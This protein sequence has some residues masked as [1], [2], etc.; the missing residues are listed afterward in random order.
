MVQATPLVLAALPQV[1]PL[2]LIAAGVA[3]VVIVIAVIVFGRVRLNKYRKS[4]N[5]IQ[6]NT[7]KVKNYPIQYRLGRVKSISKNME[8]VRADYEYFI[9][10]YERIETFEKTELEPMINNI[11]E[12]LFYGK[13]RG[14]AGKLEQ[15]QR[16]YDQYK[17][18]SDELLKNI[19][20]IT[21][22]ENTQRVEIIVIKDRY[23]EVQKAY[24]PVS[25]R[26]ESYCADIAGDFDE[27]DNDFANLEQ[28]M[29]NQ[30]FE[31]AKKMTNEIGEKV[32]ELEYNVKNLPTFISLATKVL[33]KKLTEIDALVDYLSDDAYALNEINLKGRYEEIEMLLGES[34]G[35]IN[36]KDVKKAGEMIETAN[37]NI[38]SLT[39]ELV[40]EKDSYGK[41]RERWLHLGKLM[42]QT[43]EDYQA[44]MHDYNRLQ[45][46]YII[47]PEVVTLA[48]TYQEFLD[49]QDEY[50]AIEKKLETKQFAYAKTLENVKSLVDRINQHNECIK[51][52]ITQRDEMYMTEQ[53]AVDEL[54][55]IDIV[56]LE[57]K[58][59][60]KNA[61]IPTINESYK[62]F[63]KD[64]YA[65]AHE[66]A[67]LRQER[68]IDLAELSSKTDDARDIIYQLYENVHNLVVTAEMVEEAIVF[69]NRYRSTY[70]EVNTE[71]TKAEVLFRN[72]EYTEALRRAIDII[73]RIKP[74]SYESLLKRQEESA[75]Y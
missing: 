3:I 34:I 55:N 25:Q 13:T 32:A 59:Q 1:N 29:N 51:E 35:C 5:E 8:S 75:A 33:P 65:K 12:S 72:G 14:V 18:D 46:L 45:S 16:L 2:V 69:G 71:L 57:I 40:K 47:N 48:S 61:H 23:R 41:F 62:D 22:I 37:E 28:L 56:L 20:K 60:I 67:E 39:K 64:A 58:S 30:K 15:V 27:I 42:D 19:E 38:N 17:H 63:I 53:R 68:P 74:G 7:N 10:E 66:I 24:A 52:F 21:E 73:E 50:K 31:E 4:I 11:D 6:E 54:E 9:K 70:L 43:R 49:T 44:A 36:N 26:V